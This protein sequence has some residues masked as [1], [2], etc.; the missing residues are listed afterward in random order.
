MFKYAK[1]FWCNHHDLDQWYL[2]GVVD[3]RRWPMYCNAAE[4]PEN[5][6]ACPLASPNSSKVKVLDKHLK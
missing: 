3:F 4:M 2:T 1:L 5:E 6:L